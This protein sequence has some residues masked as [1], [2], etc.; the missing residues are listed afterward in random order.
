[1]PLNADTSAINGA[2]LFMAIWNR[3]RKNLRIDDNVKGIFI[4]MLDKQL[5]ISKDLLNYINNNKDNMHIKQ[6]LTETM[7]PKNVKLAESCILH[8]NINEYAP[9]SKG[10]IAY[11]ELTKELIEKGIL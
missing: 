1:M 6:L 3:M 2:N 7:I 10:A 9:N 11:Q 4:T 8:K 5:N